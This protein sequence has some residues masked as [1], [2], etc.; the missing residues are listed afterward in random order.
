MRRDRK[1][2]A[3][4]N[5]GG[6][7]AL[8]KRAHHVGGALAELHEER[9]DDGGDD[10]GRPDGERIDHHGVEAE[11]TGRAAKIDGGQHHGGHDRHGVGF[12][13]VG[14][15]AGAVA[16]I[17][18]HIV[19]DGG[20]VARVVLR[21]SGFDLAHHVA[22]YVGA[23]GEDAAAEAREDGD[24][25][26]TESKRHKPVDDGALAF[27]ALKAVSA[28][29]KR[30]IERHRK[31]G[32]AGH[33]HARHRP[34]L[35]RHGQTRLQRGLRRFGRAHVGAH[36]NQHADETGGAGQ[37]RADQEADRD[38][39]AEQHADQH[40]YHR[41]HDGDGGVLALQIGVG[42]F[43]NRLGDLLHAV[44]AGAGRQD[45]ADLNRAVND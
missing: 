17:V 21:D 14:R 40:E 20:R 3:A 7:E 4:E 27:G 45:G 15:H 33:E 10:A 44:I 5:G 30:V 11:I 29:Q 8:V 43:L 24:Q 13:Q 38:D 16:D 32:E 35:E 34:G 28:C 31:Q 22:A 23:L 19:R 42:A 6:D 12:E 39:P 41:A 37:E 9:A 26:R 36:R 25:R 18:A 1:P 2:G